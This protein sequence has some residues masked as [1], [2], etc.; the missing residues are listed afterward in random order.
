MLLERLGLSGQ[1]IAHEIVGLV[2]GL[3][4]VTAQNGAVSNSASP[5]GAASNGT[6]ENGV[7]AAQNGVGTAA[8]GGQNGAK[9]APKVT[10]R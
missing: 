2:A 4:R 1:R 8:V 5:N 6:P 9:S 10:A 3:G 7:A